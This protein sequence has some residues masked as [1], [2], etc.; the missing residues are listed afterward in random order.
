VR[1][2][3]DPSRLPAALQAHRRALR[4]AADESS[5]AA[6]DRGTSDAPAAEHVTAALTQTK[7][8]MR[9]AAELLGIERRRLYRLCEKHGIDPEPFRRGE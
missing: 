9:A 4:A 5:P 1:W 3:L 7:G 6:V 2:P 8:S